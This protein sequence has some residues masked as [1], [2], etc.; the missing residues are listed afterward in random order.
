MS[1][2]R[3]P[4]FG[5]RHPY[6]R[7][8]VAALALS[9]SV[10][11]SSACTEGSEPSPEKSVPVVQL[12]EALNP[13]EKAAQ[14]QEALNTDKTI[15][16]VPVEIGYE[17]NVTPA[18][19]GVKDVVSI[20]Q[21]VKL[22]DEVY[23]YFIK[24]DKTGRIT[25]KTLSSTEELEARNMNGVEATNP[26]QEKVSLSRIYFEGELGGV[27]PT[28][29]PK[30]TYKFYTVGINVPPGKRSGLGTERAGELVYLAKK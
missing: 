9:S 30:P 24:D 17:L 28:V 10:L 6:L 14:I 20:D 22:S 11:L 21:P 13:A 8:G 25:I 7:Q 3:G 23:G 18:E 19:V 5:N 26:H 4:N 1:G 12:D 27:D 15:T 29:S 16:E 2:E